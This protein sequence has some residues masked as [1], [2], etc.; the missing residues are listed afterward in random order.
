LLVENDQQPGPNTLH[1]Q[2]RVLNHELLAAANQDYHQIP[3]AVFWEEATLPNSIMSSHR[4]YD[5]P[6][7]F[8]HSLPGLISRE[9]DLDEDSLDDAAP[10]CHRNVWLN[11][12]CGS[13]CPLPLPP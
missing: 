12:D 2:V 5:Q 1:S 8:E 3:E 9:N 7:D 11:T 4:Y 6:T 13:R 10:T